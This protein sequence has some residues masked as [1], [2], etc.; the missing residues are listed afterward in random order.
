MLL[1]L[2][3]LVWPTIRSILENVP[4]TLKKNVYSDVVA[5]EGFVCAC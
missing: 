2:L 4:Y 5:G 1:N 3:R